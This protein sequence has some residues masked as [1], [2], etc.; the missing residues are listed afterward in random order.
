MSQYGLYI[1]VTP[2]GKLVFVGGVPTDM[3]ELV[4]DS[5]SQIKKYATNKGYEVLPNG[6]LVQLVVNGQ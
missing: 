3:T 6:R 4:F 1:N 2:T 5:L